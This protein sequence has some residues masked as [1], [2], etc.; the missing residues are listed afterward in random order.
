VTGRQGERQYLTGYLLRGL[1]DAS[2]DWGAGIS[3]TWGY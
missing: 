3:L 1:S 2:P